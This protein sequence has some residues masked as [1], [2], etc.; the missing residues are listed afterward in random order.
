MDEIGAFTPFETGG[1]IKVQA[2]RL[3]KYVSSSYDVWLGMITLVIERLKSRR[4]IAN[5]AVH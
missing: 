3:N 4:I 1:F 5:Y 2:I